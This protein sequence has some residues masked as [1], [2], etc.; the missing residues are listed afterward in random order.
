VTRCLLTLCLVA[1]CAGCGEDTPTSPSSALT[2][3]TESFTGTLAVNG[4]RFYAFNA[5][6]ASAVSVLLGNLRTADTRALPS[7]AVG[8]GVGI[9]AG[10]G[11]AVADS[12]V[13]TPALTSQFQ[14]SVASGI[15]CVAIFDTGA[16]TE[17]VSFAIRFSHF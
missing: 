13:T 5:P 14:T 2:L 4:Q 17:T 7:T 11:C 10:T 1:S 8:L 16:L 6:S 9:P 3:T 12:V 15:H